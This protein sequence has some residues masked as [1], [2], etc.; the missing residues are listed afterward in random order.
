MEIISNSIFTR[1]KPI[2]IFIFLL[3][4]KL[5]A[6]PATERGLYRKEVQSSLKR[7][8]DKREIQPVP[9]PPSRLQ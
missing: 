7:G 3:T 5:V 9:V 1:E 8:P 6:D 4:Q 2:L